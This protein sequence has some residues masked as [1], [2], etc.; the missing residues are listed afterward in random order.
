MAQAAPPSAPSPANPHPSFFSP[1]CHCLPPSISGEID[2][3]SR[4]RT[5]NLRLQLLAA[6]RPPKVSM[7]IT[8][9]APLHIDPNLIA[10]P[11]L[12]GDARL[13]LGAATRSPVVCGWC[14]EDV[15]EGVETTRERTLWTPALLS[16]DDPEPRCPNFRLL[17]RTARIVAM[18]WLP[19]RQPQPR[20]S[21]G[22]R[23]SAGCV[24]IRSHRRLV[25]LST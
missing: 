12:D 7:P 17:G 10:S 4:V 3:P 19:A 21:C 13:D 6:R 18:T 23:R 14:F 25:R 20:R 22:D 1:L 16:L 15:P 2:D 9:A 11:L 8:P 24:T 5:P